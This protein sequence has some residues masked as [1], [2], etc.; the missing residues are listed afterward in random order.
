MSKLPPAIFGAFILFFLLAAPSSAAN[1]LQNPGFENEL[2]SVWGTFGTTA[3]ASAEYKRS[4]NLSGK[5]ESKTTAS[6][7]KYIYQVVTVE[8][9]KYYKVS[10][11]AIKQGEANAATSI[12][13]AFYSTSDGSGPQISSYSSNELTANTTDFQFLATDAIEAPENA[14][15]ARIR[16]SIQMP[17]GA[18]MVGIAYFDDLIFEEVAPQ[19][20]SPS[21]TPS[22][23]PSPIPTPTPTST[24]TPTLSPKPTG[25]S[26]KLTD[27]SSSKK[28]NTDLVLGV[29]EGS[30]AE[31][32]ESTAS[33]PEEEKG[34]NKK[35]FLAIGLIALGLIFLGVAGYAFLRERSSGRIKDSDEK[36]S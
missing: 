17:S 13:F 29:Q 24:P 33:T 23:T 15:S 3:T 32:T 35:P 11:Y 6:G 1:I 18:T 34:Q 25:V 10:A 8:L 36:I 7:V 27:S 19:M 5:V 26:A 9:G 4:G 12:R 14:L 31:S 2:G 28:S 30:T 22:P 16:P 20:P 21:P